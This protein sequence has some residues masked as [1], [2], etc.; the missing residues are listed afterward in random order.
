VVAVYTGFE[1]VLPLR[2]RDVLGHYTNR[3]GYSEA[4]LLPSIPTTDLA[5]NATVAVIDHADGVR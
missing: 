5:V 2:Q 1:P 3:P 4:G